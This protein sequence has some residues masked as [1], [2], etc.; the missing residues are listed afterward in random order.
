[1]SRTVLYRHFSGDALLYVG[2]S[3]SP[4]DRMHQHTSQS[5]WAREITH[6][7][8]EHFDTRAAAIA[9]ER[10]AIATEQPRHNKV[11]RYPPAKAEA[12]AIVA[13]IGPQ[14]IC[15]ALGVGGHS[16]RHALFVGKF[17][18]NWYLGILMLCEAAGIDCPLT[19][20]TWKAAA[21]SVP[22]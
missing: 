22:A 18:S 9:A 20:F 19:A 3:R 13:I 21:P 16:V 1:M 10:V 14:A 8:H 17:P 7:T 6:V 12:N 5:S 2:V 4:S 11:W 15:D